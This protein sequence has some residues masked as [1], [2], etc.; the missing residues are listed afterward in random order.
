MTRI[1]EVYLGEVV[2][3]AWLCPP[4]LKI[5]EGAKV[6]RP[7]KQLNEPDGFAGACDDCQCGGSAMG[8]PTFRT[9]NAR[10]EYEAGMYTDELVLNFPR[11]APVP[12]GP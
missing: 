11:P 2:S 4:C 3:I 9:T 12:D 6:A 1:F 10:R 8:P 5:R 7:P